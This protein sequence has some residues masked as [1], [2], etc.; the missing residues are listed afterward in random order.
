MDI[1]QIQLLVQQYGWTATQVAHA[2]GRPETY[3]RQVMEEHGWESVSVTDIVISAD[4]TEKTVERIRGQE[5]QKQS[6]TAPLQALAEI[7]LLGKIN[8]CLAEIDINDPSS[9]RALGDLAK[10]F[11]TLKQNTITAQVSEQENGKNA[12]VQVQVIN[13]IS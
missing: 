10:A 13:Q 5:V 12:A 9:P 6:V 4:D 2:I 11:A 7:T 3:V 1:L 8:A